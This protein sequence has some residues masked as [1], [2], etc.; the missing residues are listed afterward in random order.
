VWADE[1]W[2]LTTSVG[3]DDPIPG[4]S[5]L[6]PKRHIPDV[7]DLDGE[8]ARTLGGVLARVTTALPDVTDSEVVYVYVFGEGIRHLHFHLAPVGKTTRS[9]VSSS[10]GR[11]RWRRS[12]AEPAGS[13][14]RISPPSLRRSCGPWRSGSDKR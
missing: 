2:R 14:P 8:E 9:T 11:S 5:Y 3:A 13:L 6:E 12:R 4:F 7:T 1:H 10:A